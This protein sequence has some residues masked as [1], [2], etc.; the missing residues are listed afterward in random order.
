VTSKGFNVF[1]YD[2]AGC[3][4]LD[5]DI[6]NGGNAGLASAPGAHGGPNLTIPITSGSVAKD[7]VPRRKCRSAKGV[8]QRG[9][10]RPKGPRCDAG[11]FERGA[12]PK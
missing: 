8:D 4:T 6:A 2:D 1:S 12:Q 11:A 10:V 9:Y 5:S 3:G 7:L